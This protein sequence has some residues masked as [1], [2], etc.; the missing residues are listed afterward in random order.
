MKCLVLLLY[1]YLCLKAN[2]MKLQRNTKMAFIRNRD[3]QSFPLKA[4]IC[5]T[6]NTGAQFT[7][8]RQNLCVSPVCSIQWQRKASSPSRLP[9]HSTAHAIWETHS[10]P[11]PPSILHSDFFNLPCSGYIP[12]INYKYL[13][14]IAI[15]QYFFIFS[16]SF[17]RV[18]VYKK[19]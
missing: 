15:H 9:L 7:A 8:E 19:M 14:Y 10:W 18:W 4:I 3:F 2:K 12:Y 13:Q 11:F 1:I 5:H 17:G 6:A 16:I